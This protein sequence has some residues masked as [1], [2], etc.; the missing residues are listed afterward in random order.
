VVATRPARVSALALPALA[1]LALLTPTLTP[2]GDSA[3]HA[4]VA[5][6]SQVAFDG[7]VADPPSPPPRSL[8][9][10]EAVAW[11]RTR[12][13]YPGRA[14]LAFV[15]RALGVPKKYYTAFGAWKHSAL[16]HTGS[17]SDIPA[18]VPV[19]TK[20]RESAGHVALSLGGGW[21]RTTDWPRIG[22]VSTVRLSM[23]LVR[24]KQRYLGWTGDL[25]DLRLEPDPPPM[26]SARLLRLL[27][28]DTG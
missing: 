18:G 27:E 4:V 2:P 28:L 8:T 10:T 19:F 11:S 21:V 15:R 24:W 22:Q 16:R 5:V 26:T 20:G 9:P 14:C 1:A 7:A 6:A 3:S 13:D 23:L 25:N 17:F 12:T